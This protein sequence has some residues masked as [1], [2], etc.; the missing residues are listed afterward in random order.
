MSH[1][2]ERVS[3]TLK[4][5][6]RAIQRV[7]SAS[8]RSMVG[9]NLS[10][11]EM[12]MIECIGRRRGTGTSV[13]DIAQ[14]MDISLATVT[15]AVKKLEKKGYVSK[16]KCTQDGRRVLIRLTEAGRRVEISQRYFH[17]Q[18]AHAIERAIAGEE[19]EILLS[20]FQTIDG[21]FSAKANEL[22]A[23][24]ESAEAKGDM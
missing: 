13:T 16:E 24:N 15:V 14:E 4:H 12:H 23:Q 6:Y 5:T 9:S 20:S 3:S 2:G 10:I 21:F 8:L 18:M 22:E 17:R 1:F 19:R 11:S 7:E